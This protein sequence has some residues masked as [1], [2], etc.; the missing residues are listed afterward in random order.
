MAKAVVFI[1]LKIVKDHLYQP[2]PVKEESVTKIF[3]EVQETY[4]IFIAAR[5]STAS[6]CQ[7]CLDHYGHQFE[8]M[9]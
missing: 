3:T 5:D 2:R 9:R 4:K 7:Q 8:N 1:F 6:R